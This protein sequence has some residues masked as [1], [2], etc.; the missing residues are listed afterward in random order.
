MA[1]TWVQHFMEV[2]KLTAEKSSDTST[3]VGAVFTDFENTQ[4]TSGYNGLPRGVQYIPERLERPLK[5][6]YFEHAER[7]AIYNAVRKGIALLGSRLYV[8]AFPCT[9][10]ARAIIQSGATQIFYEQNPELEARWKE[11]MLEAKAMLLEAGVEITCT[12]ES[13]TKLCV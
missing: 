8:T 5:Y 3:K 1:K 6:K 7:N 4:L 11:D 2:A 9:D 12:K 13:G 10:C